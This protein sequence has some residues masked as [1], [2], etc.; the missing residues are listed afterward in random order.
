MLLL[1]IFKFWPTPQICAKTQKFKNP[2]FLFLLTHARGLLMAHPTCLFS[3]IFNWVNEAKLRSP[4][5]P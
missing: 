2:I 3:P 5:Q 4:N 1:C